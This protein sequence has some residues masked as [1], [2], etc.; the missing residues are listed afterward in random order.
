[1]K[2]R[3]SMTSLIEISKLLQHTYGKGFKKKSPS[4][5]NKR[6]SLGLKHMKKSSNYS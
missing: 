4:S 5:E 2:N 6:R 1:M 3:P